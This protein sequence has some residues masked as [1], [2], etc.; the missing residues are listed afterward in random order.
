MLKAL[1]LIFSIITVGLAL[2][3]ML[4]HNDQFLS[5]LNILLGLTML[6]LGAIEWQKRKKTSA[7]LLFFVALFS[8]FAGL[9]RMTI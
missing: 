1:Q 2:Y 5:L 3:M 4:T 9:Y 6:V 7:W 8:W